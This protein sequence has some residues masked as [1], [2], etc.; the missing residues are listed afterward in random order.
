MAP[1]GTQSMSVAV[2]AIYWIGLCMAGGLGA[3]TAQSLRVRYRP[4]VPLWQKAFF[5]SLGST[6]A[7]T[8]I[9]VGFTIWQFGNPGWQHILMLPVFVWTVSILICGF[10]VLLE[11]RK[12]TEETPARPALFERLRPGLRRAE[13]YALSAEDHYVK[14]MTSAGDDL[15]LM[16]LSDAAKETAPILGLSPHRSW[17]VAE[18]AVLNVTS[19]SGKTKL[20]LVNGAQ[21]PVSRTGLKHVH[22]AGWK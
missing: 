20:E 7:V 10:G 4:L 2:R 8:L 5:Q 13:I 3:A 12:H 18:Q 6:T 21:V 17:W 14:V 11:A 16:R 19:K 15:I 9:L 1:Y 22:D